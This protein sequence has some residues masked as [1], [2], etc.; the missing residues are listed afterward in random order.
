MLLKVI[1]VKALGPVIDLPPNI[2]SCRRSTS[3]GRL[4]ADV[5]TDDIA[6]DRHADLHQD[7]GHRSLS[8]GR[9]STEAGWQGML[10]GHCCR[11]PPTSSVHEDDEPL[12]DPDADGVGAI[13]A[14][15]Y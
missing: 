3:H 1:R 9:A 5:G 12:D 10:I 6:V 11:S 8:F 13:A 4:G 15:A 7:L 2:Q 14:R